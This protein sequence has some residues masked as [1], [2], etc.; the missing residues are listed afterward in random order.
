MSNILWVIVMFDGELYK[1]R[2]CYGDYLNMLC[3]YVECKVN[4][5]VC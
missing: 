2:V 4:V 5:F 1:L 3:M